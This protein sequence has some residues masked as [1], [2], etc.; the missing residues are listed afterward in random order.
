MHF[1]LF[2]PLLNHLYDIGTERDRGDH[3]K[4]KLPHCHFE[5]S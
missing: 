4:V 3:G 2:R 1:R 5:P